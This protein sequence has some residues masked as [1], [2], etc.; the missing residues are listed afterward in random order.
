MFRV[1]NTNSEIPRPATS[2]FQPAYP[3]AR[4]RAVRTG[5]GGWAG[6]PEPSACPAASEPRTVKSRS[7]YMPGHC[8]C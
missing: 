3:G 4:S 5:A 2:D 1:T 8:T 7:S 6:K